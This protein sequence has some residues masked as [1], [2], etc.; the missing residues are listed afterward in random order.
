MAVRTQSFFDAS[1]RVGYTTLV[2]DDTFIELFGGVKNIFN[3]FQSDF[4]QGADR[5]SGYVY[6]P[7]MPRSAYLGVEI[8][9]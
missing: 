5:D 8:R 1:L 6:G 9:F 7:L 3:S 2:Y 4:D